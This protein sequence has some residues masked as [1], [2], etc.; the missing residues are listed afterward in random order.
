MDGITKR[1]PFLN[2]DGIATW[3]EKFPTQFD[4]DTLRKSIPTLQAWERE[5]MLNIVSEDDQLIRQEWIQ[6]YDE[7]PSND[8]VRYTGIGV[9]P[10]IGQ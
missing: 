8:T 3:P 4:I 1:Y 2:T 5:Y 10:A 9:D 7:L 6:Y